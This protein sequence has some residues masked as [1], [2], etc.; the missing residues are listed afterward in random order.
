MNNEYTRAGGVWT[1]GSGLLAAELADLD[2][3]TVESVNGKGGV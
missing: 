3:K 1:P 2:R